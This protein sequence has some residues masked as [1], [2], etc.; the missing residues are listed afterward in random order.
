MREISEETSFS[1]ESAYGSVKPIHR[2]ENFKE[3]TRIAKDAKAEATAREL[4]SK[5]ILTECPLTQPNERPPRIL[6][7]L[8]NF[9]W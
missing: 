8:S 2:P 6:G 3:I 1:L 4:R 5:W 7:G 9:L